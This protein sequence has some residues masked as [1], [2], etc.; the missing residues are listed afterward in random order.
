MNSEYLALD[1]GYG[2]TRLYGRKGGVVLQSLIAT[3]GSPAVS[4]W[5]AG[6]LK[7]ETQRPLAIQTADGE[8]FVGA[9]AHRAGRPIE[10]L[11]LD[12]M[13]GPEMKALLCGALATYGAPRQAHLLIALPIALAQGADGE[14]VKAEVKR[15]LQGT[16]SWSAD[17]T[18]LALQIEDVTVTSQPAGAM[19]DYFIDAQGAMPADKKTLFRSKTF[20]VLSLGFN[21]IEM[22][23][24]EEGH[25]VE[26]HVAGETAGVRRL[27][28]L[29]NP[30]RAYSL[31]ELDSKLRAGKL[32]ITTALPRW[33]REVLGQI[34]THWDKVVRR[35]ATVIVVGGGSYLIRDALLAK[36]KDRL[37]IPDDPI[38]AIA[39]GCYKFALYKHGR[40]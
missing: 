17:D 12:R 33:Q 32:D 26:K 37:F 10:N 4:S 8:F 14:R 25:L 2:N 24:A 5:A 15:N 36:F 18:Q 20:G 16:L 3:N 34:E 11:D 30:D 1:C 7:K 19:F 27:L 13:A 6:T 22:M 29:C 40:E 23:V 28:E 9:G 31:G 38:L 39:R 21:T 35:L